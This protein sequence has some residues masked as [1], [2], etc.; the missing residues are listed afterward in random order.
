M[1]YGVHIRTCARVFSKITPY[2]LAQRSRQQ[3]QEKLGADNEAIDRIAPPLDNPYLTSGVSEF[4]DAPSTTIDSVCNMALDIQMEDLYETFGSFGLLVSA[5]ILYPR[6]DE[7]RRRD[8]LC[9]FI[10][11]SLIF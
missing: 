10:A 6:N 8:H 3:L 5:K 11:S 7:E 2:T 4:E 9:G 1:I